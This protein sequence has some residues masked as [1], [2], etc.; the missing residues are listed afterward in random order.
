MADGRADG[1]GQFWYSDET[2]ETL[3]LELLDGAT[4]EMNIALVSAPSV[5]VKIRELKVSDALEGNEGDSETA[6]I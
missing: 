6:W 3:A 2:A 4:E 5:Y 1:L